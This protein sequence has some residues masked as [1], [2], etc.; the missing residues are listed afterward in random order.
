MRRAFGLA[1]LLLT[2]L[3]VASAAGETLRFEGWSDPVQP[4]Q[5]ILTAPLV[6][7]F[8]CEP[9]DRVAKTIP[10]AFTIVEQP[11]WSTLVLS[12]ATDAVD[13]ARC[14]EG[15]VRQEATAIVSAGDQAPAF[16]PGRVVFE[17]RV[18]DGG[19]ARKARAEG[20][21]V[22]SFFSILDV[23]APETQATLAPGAPVSFP[24]K[25]TNFGNGATRVRFELVEST[26]AYG[27]ALPHEL[28]LGSKQ[29]G[30]N[31]VSADV[32][33]SM[34]AP[35]TPATVARVI[36]RVTSAYASDPTLRGDEATLAFLVE[37]T[38]AETG[39]R[40]LP[41][42]SL[43]PLFVAPAVALLVRGRR[44]S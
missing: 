1:C 21:V 39:V 38:P 4:L 15:R 34:R 31:E 9:L 23:Q 29:A 12:P 14:A 24:V 36:V 18:G 33:V 16:Q 30:S 27:L 8:E 41:A 42:P 32:S 2:L 26:G 5:G 10:L 19:D 44:R 40:A 35:E 22:A 20:E 6:L 11:S 3:P 37:T 7:E 13:P 17:A 43:L 28:D 25:V